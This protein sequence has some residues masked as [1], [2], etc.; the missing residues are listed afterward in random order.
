MNPRLT[1]SYLGSIGASLV[2][3][4]A[5]TAAVFSDHNILGGD[6]E[7]ET[8]NFSGDQN[9][10]LKIKEG[11]NKGIWMSKLIDVYVPP[12]DMI[13]HKQKSGDLGPNQFW[14]EVSD[15]GPLRPIDISEGNTLISESS[16]FSGGHK[17]DPEKW[18]VRCSQK[19]RRVVAGPYDSEDDG[20]KNCKLEVFLDGYADLVKG[21]NLIKGGVTNFSGEVYVEGDELHVCPGDNKG[22]VDGKLVDVYVPPSDIIS[23][24]P[25]SGSLFPGQFWA[26]VNDDSPLVPVGVD[27]T[28]TKLTELSYFSGDSEESVGD[29]KVTWQDRNYKSHS[30]LFKSSELDSPSVV[31]SKARNFA[32][33]L[34]SEDNKKKYG[35]I[36]SIK[37]ES[38]KEINLSGESEKIYSIDPQSWYLFKKSTKE[39]VD[40][41]FSKESQVE[42]RLENSGNEYDYDLGSNL[43]G[44]RFS[45]EY[46]ESGRSANFSRHDYNPVAGTSYP[47]HISDSLTQ[48]GDHK[49][50]YIAR[51]GPRNTDIEGEINSICYSVEEILKEHHIPFK[52][53]YWNNEFRRSS[54]TSLDLS[55]GTKKDYYIPWDIIVYTS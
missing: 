29:W 42:V 38:I 31:E 14:A 20:E 50:V 27:K 12:S 7:S 51:L 18:Y 11:W 55:F 47:R 9:P 4:T 22:I 16:N 36:R 45:N 26:Q 34:E 3:A 19:D 48:I 49:F 17:I 28:H 13:P 41:P 23:H 40:G 32:K 37:V 54:N 33:R 53:V 39:I 44:Y 21:S 30:R 43:T 15:D 10:S 25:K 35:E 6:D 2:A 8:S 24:A 46:L 5:L 1:R 52:E